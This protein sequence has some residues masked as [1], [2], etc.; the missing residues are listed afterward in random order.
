LN[1]E[2]FTVEVMS[3]KNGINFTNTLSN[4]ADSYSNV[5]LLDYGNYNYTFRLNDE[6]LNKLTN[7]TPEGIESLINEKE[8][9]IISEFDIPEFSNNLKNILK[10]EKDLKSFLLFNSLLNVSLN[11]LLKEIDTYQNLI[12]ESITLQ[13]YNEP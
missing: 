10:S 12:P 11:E 7:L 2:Y 5:F 8:Y 3:T 4:I 13:I 1:S 6:L 9:I